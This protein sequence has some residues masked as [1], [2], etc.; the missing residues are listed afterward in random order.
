MV[1]QA[2]MR[3]SLWPVASF[4]AAAMLLWLAFSGERS[5]THVVKFEAAGVMRDVALHEIQEVEIVSGARSWLFKKVSAG[6]MV[7]GPAGTAPLRTRSVDEGLQ[8]L[9][10]A[11]PERV[12]RETGARDLAAYGLDPPALT[13]AIRGRGTF[14]IAFGV[15]NPLG[16]ARYAR[17][18]G[19]ADVLLMPRYV[20]DTWEEAVGL[21]QNKG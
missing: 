11:A 5:A 9:R 10:D 18:G 12:L 8:L 17:M 4:L 7:T 16:L 20:A 1:A 21:R 2:K 13:V 6:W 19:S 15:A 3:R 14:S